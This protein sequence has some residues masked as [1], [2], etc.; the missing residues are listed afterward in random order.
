[1][2]SV[3]LYI[4]SFPAEVQDILSEIR[5]L[6]K[7]KV[8]DVAESISYGIPAYKTNGKPLIY[9]AAFKNHIGLYATPQG[10]EQFKKELSI[11]KQ[12]K[13]SVQFPLNKPMPMDLIE[14]IID[15]KVKAN[16]EIAKQVKPKK[17]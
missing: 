14:R 17:S 13:G 9:F 1:M 6:I 4:N 5:T 10:H 8:P 7:V 11:Y 2:D 15:F 16:Q 3:T 12:G